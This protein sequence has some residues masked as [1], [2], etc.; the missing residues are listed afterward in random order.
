MGTK[1]LLLHEAKIFEAKASASASRVEK[2][3]GF[4]TSDLVPVSAGRVFLGIWWHLES[5]P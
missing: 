1:P 3:F 2:R 5:E 4:A